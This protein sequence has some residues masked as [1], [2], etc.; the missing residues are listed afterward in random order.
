MT[1]KISVLFKGDAKKTA[2]SSPVAPDFCPGKAKQ[3]KGN[4]NQQVGTCCGGISHPCDQFSVGRAVEY[5]YNL[6][7]FPSHSISQ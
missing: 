6:R 4:A 7:P 3:A 5:S 1:V 2:L